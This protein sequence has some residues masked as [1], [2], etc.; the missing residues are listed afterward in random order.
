MKTIW[1]SLDAR[2]HGMVVLLLF[3]REIERRKSEVVRCKRSRRGG[4]DGTRTRNPGRE[5]APK[6][7]AVA[8]F[9]TPPQMA[10]EKRP[11]LFLCCERGTIAAAPLGG[12][13]G[14]EWSSYPA[15]DGTASAVS[16]EGPVLTFHHSS[17]CWSDS[18][19]T[20][21]VL[22]ARKDFTT[23]ERKW[24]L[25]NQIFRGSGRA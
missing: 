12:H 25:T 17:P 14:R 1:K 22:Y 18:G 6:A 16:P 5:A 23:E 24:E 7:A 8:S 19:Q 15:G 20:G 13:S 21:T 3:D 4:G 2:Y 10:A 9:A 11:H